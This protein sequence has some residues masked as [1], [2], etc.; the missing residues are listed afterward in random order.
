M[1]VYYQ[2]ATAQLTESYSLGRGKSMTE[3]PTPQRYCKNTLGY[4]CNL[5]ISWVGHNCTKAWDAQMKYL[6]QSLSYNQPPDKI[7]SHSFHNQV[8]CT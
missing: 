6:A 3:T 5:L 8:Q 1:E 2:K 7:I 4:V